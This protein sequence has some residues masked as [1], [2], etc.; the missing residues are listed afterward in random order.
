[1]DPENVQGLH[2]LCV[3]YVERGD[4]IRA[5]KCFLRATL[6]AP[7]EDYILRHLRI[8]Q[9]RINRNTN[10]AA[11]NKN[12]PVKSEEEDPHYYSHT[13]NQNNDPSIPVPSVPDYHPSSSNNEYLVNDGNL[14]P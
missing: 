1:M 2:N 3:V 12:S 6:L 5:E 11:Q 14:F 13:E 7:H 4:L 9:Q 8:V 10:S